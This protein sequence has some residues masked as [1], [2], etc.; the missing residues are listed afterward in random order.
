MNKERTPDWRG[1]EIRM[2]TECMEVNHCKPILSK[3]G[4]VK[5][6]NWY[7]LWSVITPHYFTSGDSSVCRSSKMAYYTQSA[8]HCGKTRERAHNLIPETWSLENSQVAFVKKLATNSF[9]SAP[10]KLIQCSTLVKLGK[11]KYVCRSLPANRWMPQNMISH[12]RLMI[13][14]RPIA[15]RQY[16][17]H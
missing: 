10:D 11:T 9:I 2:H 15:C 16:L 1:H 6:Y 5:V 12:C 8:S 13:T 7:I 3:S 14:Q 17:T 4:S